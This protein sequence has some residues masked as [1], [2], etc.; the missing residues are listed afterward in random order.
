[1]K[2]ASIS[3]KRIVLYY[4]IF[5]A[6]FT[7][8][9]TLTASRTFNHVTLTDLI[10]TFLMTFSAFFILPAAAPILF[11]VLD[12]NWVSRVLCIVFSLCVVCVVATLFSQAPLIK[13][14]P[15]NDISIPTEAFLIRHL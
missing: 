2:K 14:T 11:I 10:L 15:D 3:D 6:S 9:I 7:T 1:M 12:M 5:V 8:L 13:K 4:A